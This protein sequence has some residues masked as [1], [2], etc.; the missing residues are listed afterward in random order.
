MAIEK[1]GLTYFETSAKTQKNLKEGFNFIVNKCF[2]KLKDD[3]NIIIDLNDHNNKNKG[4][5]GGCFGRKNK[6]KK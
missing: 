6:K 4:E 5:S 2:D 1:Y 3:K